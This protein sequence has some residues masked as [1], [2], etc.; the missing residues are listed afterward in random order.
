[1]VA[2]SEARIQTQECLTLKSIFLTAKW[3]YALASFLAFQISPG[4]F[5][6]TSSAEMLLLIQYLKF[7]QKW[8]LQTQKFF[9]VHIKDRKDLCHGFL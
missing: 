1:M 9:S 7:A 8:I 2:N 4:T 3:S 6:S 5:L